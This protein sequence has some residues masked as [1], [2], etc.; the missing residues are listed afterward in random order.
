MKL[1][2]CKLF[3]ESTGYL[4]YV[5]CSGR[6]ESA[7][8]TTDVIRKLEHSTTHTDGCSILGMLTFSGGFYRILHLSPPVSVK[9]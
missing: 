5:T 1:R 2:K 7:E 9:H 8:H 6:L 3:A 4:G